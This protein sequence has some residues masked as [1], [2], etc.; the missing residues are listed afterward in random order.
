MQFKIEGR[1]VLTLS[2]KEGEKSSTHVQTDFN[3]NV[4]KEL[5]RSKY[6]DKQDMPTAVGTKALT[7]ALVHG[8]IGNIH[9]GHE[10]EFWDDA[11]HLRF[12]IEELKRGVHLQGTTFPSTF[13]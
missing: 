12:I 9:Y 10:K 7:Q 5:N 2:H 11:D 13:E 8:L 1:S 4:S 3:L 6:L